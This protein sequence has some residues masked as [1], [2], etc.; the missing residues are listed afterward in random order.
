MNLTYELR[1]NGYIILLNG[2]PWIAQGEESN[3]Y[4]PN[5]VFNEDGS[6]NYEESCLAHINEIKKEQEEVA[7][8]Q[9]QLD[10]IEANTSYLVMMS[11]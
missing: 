6:I 9:N 4:F 1:E 3:G 10:T 7:L 2:K 8:K 5:P 11:E